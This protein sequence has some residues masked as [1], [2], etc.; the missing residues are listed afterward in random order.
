MTETNWKGIPTRHAMYFPE[1]GG[2]KFGNKIWDNGFRW[3]VSDLVEFLF[4]ESKM[5]V[6]HEVATTY[7]EF[8]L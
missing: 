2:R 7:L 4:P 8:L 3:T 5:P 6:F 1:K